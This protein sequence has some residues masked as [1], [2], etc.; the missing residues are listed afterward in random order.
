MKFKTRLIIAFFTIILIPILLSSAMVAVLG[1]YQ[2]GAIDRAYGITG[3]TVE[4]LSNPMQV[5]SRVTEEPYHELEFLAEESPENLEDAAYLEEF[6][7]KLKGKRTY[8]LVRKDDTLVYIGTDTAEVKEVTAQLPGYGE[9]D[10]T[11]ENGIYLGGEAQA[12]LKQV[13]FVYPGGEKGSAFIITDVSN[14]I[15]EVEQ[16]FVDMLL[17][18]VV[19]LVLT[20][21]SLI[22]WIYKGV[23]RPI[24]K[25]QVAA[26]N[27]KEGNLDFELKPD[28]C[29][30]I[31]ELCLSLEDMR[32][33]L[34][35]NAEEKLHLIR[36]IRS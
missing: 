25:M 2:I 13:D 21:L 8:L 20:A 10:I 11:S 23:M 19:V 14:V 5:L 33:R 4:S 1:R 15:P 24:E 16:F 3:T 31:G 36:K 34:K 26:C 29:D 7:R 30:E 18:I 17:C 35:D 27:I 32:K 28:A 9:S 6:N 12:L 22:F